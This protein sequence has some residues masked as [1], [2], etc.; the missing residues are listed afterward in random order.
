MKK[1]P[2]PK[3]KNPADTT[4]QNINALKKRVDELEEWRSVFVLHI[5]EINDRLLELQPIHT[6]V[7]DTKKKVKK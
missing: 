2:E 3:K 5:I 4:M 1:K 7:I 6:V